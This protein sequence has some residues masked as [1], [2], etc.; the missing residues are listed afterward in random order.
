MGD[1]CGAARQGRLGGR[2]SRGHRGLERS[3]PSR[4]TGAGRGWSRAAAAPDGRGRLRPRRCRRRRGSRCTAPSPRCREWCTRGRVRGSRGEAL[5]LALDGRAH[6]DGR[7]V[8]NV[9]VPPRR[10]LAGRS[11]CVVEQA[12]L[13]EQHEGPLRLPSFPGGAL[14]L[15][16]LRRRAAEVDGAGAGDLGRTPRDRAVECVVDLEDARAVAPALETAAVARRQQISG[17]REQLSRR[18]VADDEVG[19]RQVPERRDA[20]TRLDL[21]AE[22]AQLGGEGVGDRLRPAARE[23]PPVRV[24]EP[25]QSEPE[26]GSAFAVE[27]QD[28]MCGG[29]EEQRPRVLRRQPPR[30]RR[31]PAQRRRGETPCTSRLSCQARDVFQKEGG[32]LD[33]RRDELL[34]LAPERPGGA[35]HDEGGAVVERMRERGGRVDPFDVEPEG[36]EERR[37]RAE[38]VDRGADVVSEARERQLQRPCAAADRLLRLEDEDGASGLREGDGGGEPVR[39]RADD[40]RV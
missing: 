1:P 2:T 7:A 9:A 3:P 30:D 39:P 6:I 14:R 18:D 8:R 24:C 34:V 29:P 36:V 13:R 4:R 22:L 19:A 35:L 37:R 33:R 16:D 21:A 12:L 17:E 26:T 20:V 31:R 25:E 15:G 5:D 28:R 11:T 10:V 32:D 27:R 40:D 38:R 23:R